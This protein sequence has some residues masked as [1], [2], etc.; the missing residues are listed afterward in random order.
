MTDQLKTFINTKLTSDER[1]ELLSFVDDGDIDNINRFISDTRLLAEFQSVLASLIRKEGL[2]LTSRYKFWTIVF[3]DTSWRINRSGVSFK[4]GELKL[5]PDFSA[6]PIQTVL[7]KFEDLLEF[8]RK[9]VDNKIFEEGRYIRPF[10]IGEDIEVTQHE[11]DGITFYVTE[12]SDHKL[13]YQYGN[14]VQWDE[15]NLVSAIKSCFKMSLHLVTND[16]SVISCKIK[17]IDVKKSTGKYAEWYATVQYKLIG[18]S[19]IPLNSKEW[20]EVTLNL[21]TTKLNKTS[22]LHTECDKIIGSIKTNYSVT[23]DL[24]QER[25]LNK[26]K[27]MI[28]D[29][30]NK[31][32]IPQVTFLSYRSSLDVTDIHLTED[33]VKYTIMSSI[34][35]KLVDENKLAKIGNLK[36]EDHED[37]SASRCYNYAD[38]LEDNRK[39]CQTACAEIKSKKKVLAEKIN[40]LYNKALIDT[41]NRQDEIAQL[42]TKLQTKIPDITVEVKT[43]SEHQS[44]SR[45]RHNMTITFKSPLLKDTSYV[46]N[47]WLDSEISVEDM[48]NRVLKKRIPQK[49]VSRKSKVIKGTEAKLFTFG[50]DGEE[51]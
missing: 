18:E 40:T 4:E 25:E 10:Y 28:A 39:K 14:R 1:E 20:M 46:V 12:R 17:S 21:P 30:Y 42:I 3:R 9:D 45:Y 33:G 29:E 23:S 50:D 5:V 41:N 51:I 49:S 48:Y 15:D 27:M 47:N 7:F 32:G 36:I 44:F 6:D 31:I 22:L 19:V 8:I 26:L 34:Y 37:L 43:C 2:K 16:T 35:A 11:Y 38:S 13:D 24:K